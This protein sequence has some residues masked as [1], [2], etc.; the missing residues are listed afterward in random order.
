[1]ETSAICAKPP[2]I[3]AGSDAKQPRTRSAVSNGSRLFVVR[4]GDTAWSRRF[5][6]VLA[7]I[8]GDLGGADLLSEGQRQLARRCTTI[9]IVCEKMEGEA[10]AGAQID[11]DAY[12][13][14]TDRLGRAFQ[15]LGLKKQRNIGPTLSEYLASLPKDGDAP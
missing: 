1:M 13:T 9:A 15:R 2:T 5:S 12:G 14:L 7:E 10:A 11:L 4:P 8:I 3:R 6:D